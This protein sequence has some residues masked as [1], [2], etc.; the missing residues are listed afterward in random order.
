MFRGVLTGDQKV[1]VEGAGVWDGASDHRS[2]WG[3]WV[4][5]WVNAVPLQ[6]RN[7]HGVDVP[8]ETPCWPETTS[9]SM[10]RDE[11]QL[12]LQKRY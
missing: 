5:P 6:E 9:A 10:I 4:D 8:M 3:T 2:G 12:I 11:K 1:H 7:L